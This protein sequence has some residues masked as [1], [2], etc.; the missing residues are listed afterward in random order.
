VGHKC[1]SHNETSSPAGS[2]TARAYCNTTIEHSTAK[3]AIIKHNEQVPVGEWR[4]DES[5][6]A[7]EIF[8]HVREVDVS[9]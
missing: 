7:A 3:L 2:T 8:I 1:K 6:G 4:D 9:D 5:L